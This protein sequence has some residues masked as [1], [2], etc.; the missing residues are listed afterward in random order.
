MPSSIAKLFLWEGGALY[1]GPLSDNALHKHHAAQITLGLDGPF[2]LKYGGKWQEH[3][4]IAIPANQP[5]QLDGGASLLAIALIDGATSLGRSIAAG[6]FAPGCERLSG[7]PD[8]LAGARAFVAHLPAHTASQQA[9]RVDRR[10]ARVMAALATPAD[11]PSNAAALARLAALSESRFL[12][13]FKETTGLPLR[14]Y[15]LWRRII[16]S[17]EAAGEGADLTTAAQQGGFS[18]SAHFSRTFRETF[19]LSPSKLLKNSQNIQVITRQTD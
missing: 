12:H 7:I 4:A 6:D 3:R 13:L 8:T 5:H 10:I 1:F 9:P 11:A 18:D 19:G 16:S 15:I 2:R 14:R 17:I